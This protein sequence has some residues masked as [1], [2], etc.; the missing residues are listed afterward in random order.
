MH[1][2]TSARA[3]HT[4][5]FLYAHVLFSEKP[6]VSRT[7]EYETVRKNSN[8]NNL[9]AEGREIKFRAFQLYYIGGRENAYDIVSGMPPEYP[10]AHRCIFFFFKSVANFRFSIFQ[11]VRLVDA[12]T[13]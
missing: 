9:R 10:G 6:N 4:V 12:G 2:N 7:H 5:T 13:L 1:R 3:L 8:S 11:F